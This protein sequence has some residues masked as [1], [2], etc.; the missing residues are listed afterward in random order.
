[1]GKKI[2]FIICTSLFLLSCNNEVIYS[3]NET[4]DEWIHENLPDIQSMSRS[5]WNN[6]EEELK[7]P[8]YRAFTIQQRIDFWNE[9]VTETLSLDWTNA[10]REHINLVLHFVNQY[11]HCL[12]GYDLLSDKEKNNFDLF[13]Y[14]WTE[15]AT[16]E[17]NWSK[18]LIYALVVSTN[19]LL[20][21]KGTL[22][23]SVNPKGRSAVLTTTES[24]CNCNIKDNWCLNSSCDETPCE[25]DK[26]KGMLFLGCGF[27]GAKECNGRCGGI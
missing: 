12:N 21:T 4:I 16:N 13:F 8:V 24:Q 27:L 11:P 18:E 17:L 5:E 7:L 25:K 26:E 22:L 10:E 15:K 14:K 2:F 6:L 19:K 23:T 3:C 1:M 20:D 9:K